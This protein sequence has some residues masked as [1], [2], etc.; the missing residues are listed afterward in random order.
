MYHYLWIVQ[1]V[2]SGVRWR[3]QM[4]QFPGAIHIGKLPNGCITCRILESQKQFWRKWKA[5]RYMEVD[6][7]Q[8]NSW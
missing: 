1:A 3:S 2:V 4:S 7:V 8:A 6:G 5:I